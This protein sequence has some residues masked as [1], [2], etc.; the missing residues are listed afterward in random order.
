MRATE[1]LIS[2][3]YTLIKD[4]IAKSKYQTKTLERFCSFF[5][6][7]SYTSGGTRCGSAR[8]AMYT[9]QH[10]RLKTLKE[11]VLP[12]M[13]DLE[14]ACLSATDE[15]VVTCSVRLILEGKEV[16]EFTGCSKDV[17]VA[18]ERFKSMFPTD[19][20]FESEKRFLD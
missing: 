1:F 11:R 15:P 7:V 5:N 6:E 12:M 13:H 17:E 20:V 16:I 4:E 2:Y 18:T 3:Y 9:L 19:V 14:L 8:A 10:S